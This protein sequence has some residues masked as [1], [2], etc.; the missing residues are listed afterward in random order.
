MF[1][2]TRAIHNEEPVEEAFPNARTETYSTASGIELERL[3]SIYILQGD[4]I[5]SSEQIHKLEQQKTRGAIQ[6]NAT[7]YWTSCDVYYDF[8][9]DFIYKEE[10]LQAMNNISSSVA[11]QFHPKETYNKDYVHFIHT[12]GNYSN[13]GSIGGKQ[14]ISI[15]KNQGSVTGIIM[16]ELLHA[17]GLFHEMCRADRNEYIEILWDNIEANKKSNFQTYI[18]LNTPGADIGNFDFNSIM[19]Y[20]SDAFGKQV[21]GVK[22]KTIYRKDG[23]SYYAQRS[24]LTDSDITALRAIYGPPYAKIKRVTDEIYSY[25]DG[26]DYYYE[27]N[28]PTYVEFYKDPEFTIPATLTTPR[29]LNIF[30][31]ESKNGTYT[32]PKYSTLIVPAGVSSYL[33]GTGYVNASER[34]GQSAESWRIE[35]GIKNYHHNGYGY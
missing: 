18:E 20:P 27:A 6:T 15:A 14:D 26:Y 10:A 23:L 21:N 35:Y 24:Y 17:L 31:Q 12:D 32:V 19:M 28:Y 25:D 1:P 34:W 30:R 29:Y 16:H 2:K 9:S 4:I 33:I 13:L 22:Q 8:A 3:D 5:L 11:V 7:N